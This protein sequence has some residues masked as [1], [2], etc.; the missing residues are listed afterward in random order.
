MK[1]T[2]E[3]VWGEYDHENLR[4]I[5]KGM[6]VARSYDQCPVFGDFLPYKS[7]TVICKQKQA[8]EVKYW[9][10]YVHGPNNI[11]KEMYL[12]DGRI[13]IRSNYMCW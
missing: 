4:R 10:T 5:S 2:K 6:I 12:E 9:L 11:E 3:D 8:D 1:L 7:V 13:A